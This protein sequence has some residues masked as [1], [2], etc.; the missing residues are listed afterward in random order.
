SLDRALRGAYGAFSVQ[1]FMGPEG[2]VGETRQGNRLADAAKAAGV[3]HFVYTSVGGADRKSGL[4]HF[5]SKWQ[6]EE[7]IRALSLPATILRPVFFMDNLRSPWLGPR[8]G[9]LAAGL[10]PTTSLQMIAAD[11]IGAFAALAFARPQEYIGKALEI[12]G[13]SLTGPQVA[14]ALTRTTGQPVRFVEQPLEQV[15]SF[16]AEMADM[17]AWFNDHGYAADIPA[18]RKLHPGLMTFETWLRKTN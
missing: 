12:A 1:T 4:P 18:L 16:N 14:H 5:E 13:D 6:I 3:Q 9:V 15:R 11:D 10:R 8:D 7:H 17:F 2:S